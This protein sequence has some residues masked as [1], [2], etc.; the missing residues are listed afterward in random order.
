M[1]RQQVVIAAS[2]GVRKPGSE[3]A[4]TSSSGDLVIEIDL[5]KFANINE[6]RKAFNKALFEFAG[7]LPP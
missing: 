2:A 3:S 7:Q 1:A 4:G 6:L 5:T